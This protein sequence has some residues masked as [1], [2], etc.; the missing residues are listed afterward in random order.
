MKITIFTD[1]SSRGNPGP[2]GWGAIIIN[3]NNVE[4]IGGREDNTTN[5]RMEL[6]AAIEALRE[7]PVDAEVTINSDSEYVVKGMKEWINGWQRNGWKNSQ[8]KEVINRDLWENLLEATRG[9]KIVWKH[10]RG[11]SDNGLNNRCDE[12]ATSFADNMPTN[13]YKGPISGYFIKLDHKPH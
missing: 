5:N 8:K 9:Q 13:L 7:I 11:H 2:G 6:K 10:I 12:I 1:G 4:E 3:E